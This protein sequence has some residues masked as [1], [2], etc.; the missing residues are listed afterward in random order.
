MRVKGFSGMNNV[1]DSTAFLTDRNGISTPRVILNADVSSDRSLSKRSGYTKLFSLTNP[2]SLSNNCSI[3][4]CVA[5]NKLCRLDES[6]YTELCDVVTDSMSYAEV[7]N[8]IYMSCPSWTGKYNLLSEGIET[9]GLSLPPAPGVSLSASGD[10]LPGIYSLCYTRINSDGSISGNGPITTIK[11]EGGDSRGISLSNYSAS[12]LCWITDM[13]GNDF[14]LATVESDE[15]TGQNFNHPLPSMF[16]IPP[17]RMNSITYAFGRIWGIKDKCLYYSEPNTYDWWKEANCVP[18]PDNIVMVAP[19]QGAIF[20]ASKDNTWVLIGTDPKKMTIQK[21]GGGSVLGCQTYGDFQ[22]SG[23]EISTWRH[24]SRLPI[25]ISKNGFIVGNEHHQVAGLTETQLDITLGAKG[26]ILKRIV[27][28]Q[29]QI[30]VSM[31]VPVGTLE[32]AFKSGKIF[33]K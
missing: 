10:M 12:Y 16:I 11:F 18:F 4:L 23:Q 6:G 25:W 26:A 27:G 22:Q 5:D 1:K 20:V 33:Q 31:P 13:N 2:H 8:Y 19:T 17:P 28:G 30:L 9:W 3:L 32:D 7:G 14:Y 21:K 29:V 24:K 15:I